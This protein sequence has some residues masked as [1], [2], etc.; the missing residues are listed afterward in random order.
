MSV[1]VIDTENESNSSE[2]PSPRPILRPSLSIPNAKRHDLADSP[3]RLHSID[4][5]TSRSTIHDFSL[6]DSVFSNIR[7]TV[8]G[9]KLVKQLKGLYVND[10]NE[11]EN[12][13]QPQFVSEEKQQDAI[14]RIYLKRTR[15]KT[16][17]PTGSTTTLDQSSYD[18]KEQK[19]FKSNNR[20]ELLYSTVKIYQLKAGTLEKIVECL[21]NK[22]GDLDTIHMHTVFATYRTY[23]NTRVLIETILARYQAVV[24]ASL[25][26]IEDVRQKTLKSLSM[27]LICL[28]TTYKEDF[29]EPPSFTTL[30]YLRENIPVDNNDLENQCQNLFRRFLREGKD[31]LQSDSDILL[32]TNDVDNNNNNNNNNNKSKFSYTD[33]SL[34]N[35]RSVD[36]DARKNFLD[37]SNIRIAE[38]LTIV[39]AELLKRVL[40]YEC[41]TLGK[42]IISR[43]GLPSNRSLSTADKTIEHFNALTYRVVATI[44]KEQNESIR[45]RVIEKWIDIAYECRQLKNFSSLTAILNGLES[46]C[47]YR[48]LTAWSNVDFNHR[49]K[50]SELKT[51]FGS[52]NGDKKQA[53]A[54]LEKQLDEIRLTLPECIEGTA[55][56]TDV[57]TAAS[58]TLGRKFRSKKSRDQQ[59]TMIGTVPYLG[60]YFSDLTYIDSAFP[61]YININE[62]DETS[63]KLI[64]FEKHRREFEIL[65]Q[66]KLFQSAAN[67][68]TSIQRIPSFQRWFDN[69]QTH[70]D[71]ENWQRSYDIEPQES[72]DIVDSQQQKKSQD[73]CLSSQRSQPLR[74]FPS[75]VSL[76][77][78]LTNTQPIP[79]ITLPLAGSTTSLSSL[80]KM[81]YASSHSF[82][83]RQES[84]NTSEKKTY[85]HH[86]RSS[87]ASSF[88]TNASSSQ[89]YMSA[90]GSPTNSVINCIV[91]PVENNTLIAK[92]QLIGRDDLLYKK[93]RIGDNER[94][95]NVLKIILEKFNLDPTTYDHYCIDQ[96]LADRKITLTDHCNVF[97]AL[98]RKS[99]DEHVD[100]IVRE[101][102]RQERD[103]NKTRSHPTTGHNR[104]PSG[105]S[106]SS[107]HSR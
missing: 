67:A 90:Q 32:R 20:G 105:L 52:C 18:Q 54:I 3:A 19:D 40:P 29:Y 39:D 77:S 75:Q 8:H 103:Q 7:I 30:S 27:S 87:S 28:L 72:P 13:Q 106:V 36:S 97:Y 62:K 84:T 24:P 11:D 53:R 15:K 56:Y 55:K 98:V 104:T 9:N 31:A 71:S 86:S 48:L 68:Y 63:Q 95:S 17:S 10:S 49:L 59:N 102:T 101:K 89:G 76:E 42:N 12:F 41:L 78:L 33:E 91:N 79:D 83:Q 88:L 96:Q 37:M 1:D 73:N 4:R 92:V 80:D 5:Q 107:N 16:L 35:P 2:T 60:L 94:V 100:L 38:Q 50:L 61:N 47:I 65:A 64:N 99:P 74:A 6:F 70:T 69:I 58:A 46:G 82:T 45:A 43:S 14:F 51:V 22:H 57:T 25:D 23:T 66:I 21:T 26:M 85:S 44:L 93:V 34:Y 81:S